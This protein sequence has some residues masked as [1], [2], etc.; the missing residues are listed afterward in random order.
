MDTLKAVV[1]ELR[2]AESKVA[3]MEYSL[4]VH[5]VHLMVLVRVVTTVYSMAE[6]RVAAKVEMKADQLAKM[7]VALLEYH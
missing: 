7:W 5:S 4:A 1:K 6:V 3:Q 2:K